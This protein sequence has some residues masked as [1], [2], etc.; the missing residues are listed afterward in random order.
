M[1]KGKSGLTSFVVLGCIVLFMGYFVVFGERGI[2]YLQKL[3]S[4]LE[5][6]SAASCD[7]RAENERLKNEITLLQND[8]RSIEKIAR[9]KLGLVKKNEIIYKKVK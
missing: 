3:R 9:E 4:E 6:V 1:K 8:T 5:I 7:L 2:L